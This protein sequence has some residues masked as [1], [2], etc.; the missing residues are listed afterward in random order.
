MRSTPITLNTKLA[1]IAHA[2]C[3]AGVIANGGLT[4]FGLMEAIYDNLDSI[5]DDLIDTAKVGHD[6]GLALDR[7]FRS[8]GIQAATVRDLRDALYDQ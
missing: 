3:N 4:G 7:V 5:G 6:W 1:D 8:V 2:H